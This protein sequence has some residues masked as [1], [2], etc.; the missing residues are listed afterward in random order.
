MTQLDPSVAQSQKAGQSRIV[1]ANN[2]D[3][4]KITTAAVFHSIVC[5]EIN[6]KTISKSSNYDA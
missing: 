4:N 5:Q 6:L 2:V 1:S 3:D